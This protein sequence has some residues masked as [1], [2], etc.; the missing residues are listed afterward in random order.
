MSAIK[1]YYEDLAMTTAKALHEECSQV[2]SYY[3]GKTL[4]E[5]EEE[6]SIDIFSGQIDDIFGELIACASEFNEDLVSEFPETFSAICAMLPW[7]DSPQLLKSWHEI[8]VA[9]SSSNVYSALVNAY[10]E[11]YDMGD[12]SVS[13]AKGWIRKQL[14]EKDY[15]GILVDLTSAIVEREL[16]ESDSPKTFYAKNLISALASC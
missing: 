16:T 14:C 2:D 4:S 11:Y 12:P 3:E 7:V 8:M 13:E 1:R 5:I 6:I 15:N 10:K 9:S